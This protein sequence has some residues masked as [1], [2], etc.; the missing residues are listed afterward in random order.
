MRSR[1]LEPHGFLGLFLTGHLK[2]TT[3][4]LLFTRAVAV[5][6]VSTWFAAMTSC[7]VACLRCGC[8]LIESGGH[9]K[10]HFSC[11]GVTD[12]CVPAKFPGQLLVASE[13]LEPV[14]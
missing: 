8:I 7:S 1:P 10:G 3:L 4:K 5:F 11:F 9:F 13:V 2:T 12:K 14:S 6:S